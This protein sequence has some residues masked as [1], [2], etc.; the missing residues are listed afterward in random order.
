M[1]LSANQAD[2]EADFQYIAHISPL[3]YDYEQTLAT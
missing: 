1:V 2:P 3:A